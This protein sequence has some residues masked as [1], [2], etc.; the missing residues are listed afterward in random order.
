VLAALK[1]VYLQ[2][3]LRD[4]IL[5]LVAADVNA[6]TPDDR[7]REGLDDRQILVLAAVRLGCNLDDDKLQDLAEQHR[8]LRHM[9]GLGDWKQPQLYKRGKAGEPVQ[10][11]RLVLVYEDGAGFITHHHLLP[12][13]AADRDVLGRLLIAREHALA[14]AASSRRFFV[15]V[16]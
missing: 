7:G 16:L 9:L 3:A 6:H 11:G 8:T 1:H 15:V 12:R 10:F 13:D 4:E 14:E 5:A 2:P